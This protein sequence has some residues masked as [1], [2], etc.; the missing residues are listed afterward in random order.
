MAIYCYRVTHISKA[1]KKRRFVFRRNSEEG[2]TL[3]EL[4]VV[5]A[6]IALLMGILLPALSRAR[7]MG[8]RAVCLAQIKQLQICWNMYC[9]ENNDKV[10]SGDIWYSW[11]FTPA[12]GGP[13]PSWHEW[14]HPFPHSMPPSMATNYNAAYPESCVENG[15]CKQ[16]E[17]YHA[18]DEGLLFKYVKDYKIYRCP[19]GEKGE[20]VTYSNVHSIKTWANP[21]DGSA[22]PGS[23]SRTI[24]L[25]SQIKRTSERAVF[26][27][28]GKASRGAAYLPY[29]RYGGLTYGWT[30]P[31]RHGMGTTFSFADGHAEYKRWT[32]PHT[33]EVIKKALPGNAVSI[34]NCDCDLRWYYG[35]VWG[36]SPY[37][38]TE[39]P[40]PACK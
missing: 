25:K 40:P 1:G 23:I 21:P 34:D 8:K 31:A 11:G 4:L 36:G 35:I 15:Q 9:D 20:F 26:I 39:I 37:A 18:I 33:L 12:D 10:P 38:C 17:W 27:D 29:D 19:V 16:R 13:Q 30:P 6:I 32:D 24:K 28:L 22:G 5:I 3:V 14:P 7:E 2:F